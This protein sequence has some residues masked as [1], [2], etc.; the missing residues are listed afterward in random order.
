MSRAIGQAPRHSGSDKGLVLS[1]RMRELQDDLSSQARRLLRVLFVRLRSLPRVEGA[2]T[3]RVA[4]SKSS[5]SAECDRDRCLPSP[6]P[7]CA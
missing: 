4:A 7:A 1:L 6:P 2:E 5:K 3:V